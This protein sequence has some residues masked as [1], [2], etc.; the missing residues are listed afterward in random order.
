MN[1]GFLKSYFHQITIQDRNRNILMSESFPFF[2]STFFAR[3]Q[4]IL[5]DENTQTKSYFLDEVFQYKWGY[6]YPVANPNFGW[7]LVWVYMTIKHGTETLIVAHSFRVHLKGI[8]ANFCVSIKGLLYQGNPHF[9][10]YRVHNF[11]F[12]SQHFLQVDTHWYTFWRFNV[13][14]LLA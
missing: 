7:K 9:A 10:V 5:G 13:K 2:S 6:I 3:R 14:K 4:G 8:R 11:Q 1:R 12:I